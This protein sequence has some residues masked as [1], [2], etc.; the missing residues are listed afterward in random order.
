M[1]DLTE[2]IA[3][4]SPEQR[5]LFAAQ[6]KKRGLSTP[7][8][9]VIPRRKNQNNCRLSFDQER[10]WIVDQIEP[11]NPAYN[12]FSVSRLSGQLDPSL[13][14]RA[15]NEVVRRHEALRTT[16]TAIDGE[17]RQ[18]ISPSLFIPLELVDLRAV[19]PDE[20]EPEVNRLL[21]EGTSRPFD[22]ARGPLARFGLIQ[23][24]DDQYVLHYTVHHTVIDRWSADIIEVEMTAIYLAFA[25]GKPSPLPELPI[26]YADFA[27][28][29]REWLQGDVLKEQV[30]YWRKRFDG[31]PQVLELPTDR[32]RPPLQT[33]HGARRT[34][35]LP[36][37]ILDSLKALTRHEHATMFMTCLAAFKTL[38][39]RYTNQEDILVGVAIANRNR[40][41]TLGLIGYFL[42]MLVMRTNFSGNPTFREL[43][44]REKTGATNDFAHG[45][46]PFGRLIQELKPKVDPSRNP[47]F[48]VAY[49]Y[50]DFVMQETAQMAGFTGSPILWDNGHARFDMTLALTDMT[51]TLEVTIEFNTDLFDATTIE[52]TLGHFKCM[53]EAIIADPD[54]RVAHLPLLASTERQ[55]M[56]LEWNDVRTAYP[57]EKPIQQLFEE[58]VAKTPD[59]VALVFGDQQLTYLELNCR[60]NRL[61]HHL[62]AMG[63]TAEVPVGLMLERSV[64]MVV[65]ILAIL[66]AGGAYV[67]LDQSYPLERL[68]FMLK[69][70]RLSVLITADALLDRLPAFFGQV[71]CIDTDLELL[72]GVSEANPQSHVT[73][74]NL[75]YV[76]YTSGSTGQPKGI[77]IPHRAVTRLVRD[78]NYIQVQASD[79]IAQASNA[80]FDAATFELWGALLNGAQ[81]VGISRDLALSP[82][83]FAAE[84]R[85]RGISVLFLTTAL[86]NQVAIAAPKAFSTVRQV[87]FGGEAVEPKW[88]RKVLA[89]GSPGVLQHVY[90]PTESTTFATWYEIGEVAEDASTV[91]IGHALS[92]TQTYVLDRN[93][94]PVPIGVPGE[95]FL[96][97]DGLARGYLWHPE[98]TA[99]RFMPD[100]FNPEGG[101]RMY[102][103]GDLVRYLPEGQIEFLGRVDNQVKVRGFRIEL[104]EIEAV[105]RTHPSVKETVVLAREDDGEERRLVAYLVC[106]AEPA[107]TASSWRIFIAQKLPEYMI[108]SAFVL[109]EKLP[110]TSNGKVDRRALPAPDQTRPEL[111]QSFMAPT[112]PTEVI[113]AGIWQRVLGVDRVGAHDSFFELGGDSLMAIQVV[114]KAR[115]AAIAISIQQLFQY[116]TVAGLATQ[117]RQEGN[118]IAP[119]EHV[120]AFGLISEEDRALLPADIVDAY[121]L[122]RLQAGMVFHSE[123]DPDTAVYHEIFSFHIRAP[124][125]V[126]L[127]RATI[128]ELMRRHPVLRT[129]FDLSNLSQPL[130]L[131]HTQVELPFQLEDLT[132]VTEDEE[133]A[134]V[135]AYI[136]SE[137][138]KGFSWSS[139]PLL[140]VLIQRRRGDTFQFNLSFHHALLDGWSLSSLLNELF[141]HYASLLTHAEGSLGPPPAIQFREFVALE[142]DAM[143]SEIQQSFWQEKLSH[144][145]PCLLPRWS[146]TR[147]KKDGRPEILEYLVPISSELS[148]GLKRFASAAKLP[149]KSVMLAAHLRVLALATGEDEVVTGL[150]LNGRP[151]ESDGDRIA[152]LFLNTLPLV[153]SLRE[154]TWVDLARSAFEAER[155]ILPFRRYPLSEMLR[156]ANAPPPF[157]VGFNY[158]HFHIAQGM[159]Q[160]PGM[161]ILDFQGLSETNFPLLVDFDLDLLTSEI[162][163]AL[164][165]EAGEFSREQIAAISGYYERTFAAMAANPYEQYQTRVLLSEAE[166]RT[167]LDWNDT[168]RAF[169][170][171]Q[172]I[173]QLFED[174]SARRPDAL[175]LEFGD[176]ELTYGEL[177]ARA[178]RL[179]HYLRRKGVGTESVVGIMLERSLEM[180]VGLLGV[181]KAGGAYLPLDS[182]YPRERLA[183]MLADAEARVVLTQS[184]LLSRLPRTEE[185]VICLDEEWAEISAET[186]E[187]P[188]TELCADNLAYI[189]YTSGSTG[190]PKGVQIMHR[191]VVRLVK[192]ND[193]AR[194]DA[195]ESL[196]QFAPLAFDASTFEIWGSLL[197]GARLIVM[198]PGPPT[199][200]E[201]GHALKSR[202]VT[203]L[204][205]TA[206]LFNLMVGEQLADLSGLRQMLAGGDVL[207]V[208]IVERFLLEVPDCVLINGYGPT[209]STTF[210]CCHPMNAP[211]EFNRSVPIGRPIANTQVYLLD[212]HLRPVALGATGELFIGGDGLA[213]GYL[214]RAEHTAERFVPHPFSQRPGERLYRTGDLARYLPN[215]DIEFLGRVDNQVKV[216][217]FRIEPGEIEAALADHEA[218]RDAA[219]TIHTDES[220]EKQLA[221]YVIAADGENEPNT[222]QLRQFLKDRLPEY[223][224]PSFFITLKQFP[225]TT[226]GKVDYRAFPVPSTDRPDIQAS[227]VAP[228]TATEEI[229]ARLWSR[230]L[231]FER[232]GVNDN[233]FELGGN[234]LSATQLVSQVRQ[235]LEVELPLRDLFQ[236]P[237]IS[238]L[239]S[240]IEDVLAMELDELSDEEAEQLLRDEF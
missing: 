227:F 216:R 176:Q 180:I 197:N 233:F 193:Y 217:G 78:T 148:A 57:R 26:Q 182:E 81:V 139:V 179:A 107:P 219:V 52:R 79:R 155:E 41:E 3:A 201:L 206:G 97:G 102:R 117:I 218:V 48:Q 188:C 104:E 213:R 9:Q 7:Q 221:A 54:T 165:Y 168:T 59:A 129:S 73:G 118:T 166:L 92:N 35:I 202:G 114:S 111:A 55:R 4:L 143:Q 135:D 228:G 141:Q 177:N 96:G 132:V 239:A 151:E 156:I 210:T 146:T 152:G 33:F 131:V 183:F 45:E 231:G 153:F 198:S 31:S 23:V 30:D 144:R 53:V 194:L 15:F 17:P 12:I 158:T 36:R 72:R 133:R 236:R 91:P 71:L 184:S 162:G 192:G 24:E 199:L 65:A 173:H 224:I 136:E 207:S 172:C 29:Q 80:S 164:K 84:I 195:G 8:P 44:Q 137:K 238:Q 175:A 64:G 43:L 99:E 103:T 209:E 130:Q 21:T 115:E 38:L 1:K 185:L 225:L 220:G 106:H 169:P 157:E 232:I 215:G 98:L 70:A 18:V 47:L 100:P 50:L 87:L 25:E 63:V 82:D 67:P 150:V 120:P 39:Y 230:V 32:P 62:Q 204:W 142:Q 240:L 196:L 229:L 154:G 37:H 223:M 51:D 121:P 181:L 167:Q 189:T 174:Q 178:N 60:A 134:R 128:E 149:L 125:D 88:V 28:W 138:R 161:E 190:Q 122:T 13:M 124:L 11:G 95:L 75:A 203:T 110:L 127:F 222:S 61:A 214:N 58:Q 16:F 42:N 89:E 147:R 208:S 34:I 90:G 234:S 163:L 123:Y 76:I 126:E 14:E 2:R 159:L 235:T 140:R 226:S 119:G 93:L 74:E 49:I 10:I 200:A 27:E 205:L 113:L 211:M 22:L 186:A 101:A 160:L 237:T 56:L 86:F 85:Q 187:N 69:D 77:S 212:L 112:S 5:T 116:P 20:R 94:E 109:L 66:K 145:P 19:P 108:P 83:D 171:E 40:P 46:F 105:L 6:L 191:G 68:D 170:R